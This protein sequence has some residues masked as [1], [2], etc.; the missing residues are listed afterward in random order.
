MAKKRTKVKFLESISVNAPFYDACYKDGR[1]YV[2]DIKYYI[3]YPAGSLMYWSSD[4]IDTYGVRKDDTQ[5]RIESL[6][7]IKIMRHI[8]AN[9]IKGIFFPTFI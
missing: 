4:Y 2:E 9:K 3:Q 8:V 1:N 7:D 5:L 6:I